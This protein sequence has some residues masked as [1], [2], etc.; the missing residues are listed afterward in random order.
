MKE[1]ISKLLHLGDM[2]LVDIWAILLLHVGLRHVIVGVLQD[3]TYSG[4]CKGGVLLAAERILALTVVK[5][6]KRV[7]HQL[8][9]WQ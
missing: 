5:Q 4:D 2:I 3:Q 6:I 1:R 8:F 7:I 9:G